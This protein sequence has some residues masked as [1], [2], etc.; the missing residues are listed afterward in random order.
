MQTKHKQFNWK[1]QLAGRLTSWLFTKRGKD[2]TQGT[3]MKQNQL[4][5]REGIWTVHPK[6]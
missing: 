6:N 2:L 5:V 3:N 4:V 1:L